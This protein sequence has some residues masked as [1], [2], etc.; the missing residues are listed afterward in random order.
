MPF[1]GY[2]YTHFTGPYLHARTHKR[3]IF[4]QKGHTFCSLCTF[5]FPLFSTPCSCWSLGLLY[6]H[7]IKAGN[8]RKI[9]KGLNHQIGLKPVWLIEYTQIRRL[10]IIWRKKTTR[11]LLENYFIFALNKQREAICYS[12]IFKKIRQ[13]LF[14]FIISPRR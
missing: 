2:D 13:N 1:T 4:L 9:N 3:T 14:Y 6:K 12:R 5:Q 8:Q 7:Y 11:N 10:I